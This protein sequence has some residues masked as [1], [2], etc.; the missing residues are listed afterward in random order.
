MPGTK[1]INPELQ[2]LRNNLGHDNIKKFEAMGITLRELYH[3]THGRMIESDRDIQ[4][5]ALPSDMQDEITALPSDMQDEIT[6]LA[7]TIVNNFPQGMNI[8]DH[9]NNK[10]LAIARI[11]IE[12][13]R[14]NEGRFPDWA[15]YLNLTSE[16][17]SR[18]GGK[19]TKKYRK[20]SRKYKKSKKHHKRKS[21]RKR[22]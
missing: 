4:P 14:D 11:I 9:L 18:S 20:K 1:N 19:K 8:S 7:R 17:I 2:K 21:R 13:K 16:I 10:I 3:I 22:R 5:T 12:Y 15:T 6:S